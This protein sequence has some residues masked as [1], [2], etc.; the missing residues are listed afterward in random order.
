MRKL[1]EGH[2]DRYDWS[3]ATRGRLAKRASAESTNLRALDDD[4]AEAFPD[5]ASVNAALRALLATQ[6]ALS[7]AVKARKRSRPAA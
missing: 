4:V 6:T 5:S 2:V 1:P 3:R 7:G